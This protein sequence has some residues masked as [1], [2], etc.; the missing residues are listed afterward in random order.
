MSVLLLIMSEVAK[1]ETVQ[2]ASAFAGAAFGIASLVIVISA[3]L[4]RPAK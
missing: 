3:A 2:L 4:G 1:N